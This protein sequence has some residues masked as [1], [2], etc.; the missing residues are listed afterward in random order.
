MSKLKPMYHS[1]IW[2]EEPEPNDP[3]AAKNCYCHGYNVF[4]EI[5]PKASWCEYLYLLFKGERPTPEKSVLLEKVAMAIANPGMRDESVRAAMNAGVGGST[6]ASSLIAAIGVGAGQYGGAREIYTLVNQWQVLGT[7]L[8]NWQSFLVSPNEVNSQIDIWPEYEH[9][10]GFNPNGESCSTPIKQSLALFS[11]LSPSGALSWLEEFRIELEITTNSPL[12]MS[13]V[14]ACALFDLGMTA[15]Q[16]EMLYLLLRLPGAAVHSLE[17]EQLG[18]K[19]FPFFGKN[20]ILTD[21]PEAIV[22]SSTGVLK[23]E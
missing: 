16:A 23:N 10:P 20:T 18:W 21:D 7:N 13:G 9:A 3:F 17:Q 5:L 1:N 15:K 4:E 8:E 6:A 22:K 14:I 12:S 2:F 11:T 19:H